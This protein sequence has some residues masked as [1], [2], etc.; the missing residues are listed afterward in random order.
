M[1]GKDATQEAQV[2]TS[3]NKVSNAD[4]SEDPHLAFTDGANDEQPSQSV[5]DE[6]QSMGSAL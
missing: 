5:A 1:K 4:T 2:D 6:E 3:Y